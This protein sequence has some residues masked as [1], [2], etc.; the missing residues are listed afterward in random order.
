MKVNKKPVEELSLA[1]PTEL[2]VPSSDLGEFTTLLYGREKIGKTSLAAQFEDAYLLMFEP[3]AKALSVFCSTIRTWK[4]MLGYVSLIEK[5]KRFKTI[6]IDPADIAFKVCQKYVCQKMAI[7]HPSDEDWGKGWNAVKDEFE[8]IVL[9][10]VNTGRGVI[11]ISHETDREIKRRN[12]SSSHR[13]QPSLPKQARDILEPLVDIWMYY[14]YD[15]EGKRTLHVTGDDMISAGHRLRHRFVGISEIDMGSS[16]E[17][18]Y[19]NF[20]KAF[21]TKGGPQTKKIVRRSV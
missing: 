16:P 6:V 4:E 18:G 14:E 17:E 2:S 8:R 1:L 9:R 15:S 7:E 5:S 11:F 12:G 10:L 21:N 19:R 20:V 13:I 3:G